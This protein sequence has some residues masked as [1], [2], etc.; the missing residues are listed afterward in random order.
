MN[1]AMV[2]IGHLGIVGKVPTWQGTGMSH[3]SDCC[4]LN[5]RICLV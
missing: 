2:A 1:L 3:A 4:Q 5:E